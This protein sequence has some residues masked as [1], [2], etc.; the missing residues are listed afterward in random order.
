MLVYKEQI[1]YTH[2]M[3]VNIKK[4]LSVCD[5][6][7]L[8]LFARDS[9]AENHVEDEYLEDA[10]ENWLYNFDTYTFMVKQDID[11]HHHDHDHDAPSMSG[12][13]EEDEDEEGERELWSAP[14]TVSVDE[15]GLLNPHKDYIGKYCDWMIGLNENI[16][17]FVRLLDMEGDRGGDSCKWNGADCGGMMYCISEEWED[18]R[19]ALTDNMADWLSRLHVSWESLDLEE[20]IDTTENDNSSIQHT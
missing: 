7:F 19:G 17:R 11:H 16:K 20:S 5:F 15:H 10:L 1:P 4:K 2:I 14:I 3:H 8:S 18:W 13:E 6:I 12:E 9:E